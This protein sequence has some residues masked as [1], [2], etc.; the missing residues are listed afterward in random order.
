MDVGTSH[1]LL[2]PVIHHYSYSVV[3]E[4]EGDA[5]L[6]SLKPFLSKN[7]LSMAPKK[8]FA[9]APSQRPF[10]S[11]S[12]Q[13]MIRTSSPKTS[14]ANLHVSQLHTNHVDGKRT[15]Q[16]AFSPYGLPDE[17]FPDRDG[18]DLDSSIEP[19]PLI[20]RTVPV[21]NSSLLQGNKRGGVVRNKGRVTSSA[22]MHETSL[23][24]ESDTQAASNSPNPLGR[25]Y[26]SFD[27][28]L[29]S[30]FM[31]PLDGSLEK[32]KIK[33]PVNGHS[34][35]TSH[36]EKHNN[37]TINNTSQNLRPY[38]HKDYKPKCTL[39][40]TRSADEVDDLIGCLRG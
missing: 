37:M 23:G 2:L 31:D 19:G 17:P 39:V 27:E 13:H 15:D 21:H 34:S 30:K 26:G 5:L 16:L 8:V 25:I 28:G 36:G 22:I 6:M 11:A 24:N 1:S 10:F 4:S 3:H 32:L 33:S 7:T 38:S 12:A 14:T 9:P 29:A 20:P 40:Y 18:N 35:A